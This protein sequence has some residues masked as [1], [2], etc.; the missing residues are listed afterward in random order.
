[1]TAP[2][3]IKTP[4][5]MDA[6]VA[7]LKDARALSIDTEA[8]GL[9]HYPVKLC[10]VQVADDHGH[11]HLADPLALPTLAPLGPFFAD[12]G[13][14]K[15]LHAADNDLGYLKRL[16]GF[17]VTNIFDTAIA[18][19]FLGVTSLS[20]DGL[21]RDFLG[22][23]PGPSRQ[24][25]DWSKRPLSAAQ[26]TYALN[27]V[28]HLIPLRERLLEA[29]RAKG[30][31]R[32]VEEE[33]AAVAAM[34]AP[35][36]VVDPDAYMKLKGA[37]DLDGRGLAVLRELAATREA[38]A[39]KT[40]RPPFMILGNEVLVAL[41][42]LKPRETA[43]ILTVKGCTAN[44]VRRAGEAIVAAVER[45]LAVPETDLPVRRPNPRPRVSGAV[46]RRSEALRAWRVEAAK[47]VEL[48]AGVIFPQRLIDRLAHDPPRDVEALAQVE[49][50]GRWRAELFGAE[51]LR[52]LA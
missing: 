18:A 30:R 40:D 8:D 42:T 1:M 38:L 28:L 25:D 9:H 10:L 39:V 32:W 29:L 4:A 49:G 43:A 37:K 15:V 19:R 13:V 20:L 27:D 33:C 17:S 6:L 12:P 21:L 22:V 26:E 34:P 11:G 41:A 3:W 36:R 35:E 5:E 46:Q 50:V 45:G 16:Y 7:S 47:R 52:R 2:L 48:D 31:D 24:K 51:L 14:I 44:V 23:D